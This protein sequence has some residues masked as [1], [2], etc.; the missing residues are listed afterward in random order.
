[1]DPKINSMRYFMRDVIRSA[2]ATDQAHEPKLF[3]LCYL[4][5]ADSPRPDLYELCVNV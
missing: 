1:M 4:D 5:R 2:K 3:G